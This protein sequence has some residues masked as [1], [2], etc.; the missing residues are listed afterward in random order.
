MKV[1]RV[2][3]ILVGLSL[4][5]ARTQSPS[6]PCFKTGNNLYQDCTSNDAFDVGVCYGYIL[7]AYDAIQADQ[8]ER[9]GST[10]VFCEPSNIV[11]QQVK[12]MV[13]AYLRPP[14][15]R[16]AHRCGG[17][18]VGHVENK[19]SVRN[20][21]IRKRGLEEEI[22]NGH[23]YSDPGYHLVFRC[24]LSACVY[25][26]PQRAPRTYRRAHGVPRLDIGG[27]GWCSDLGNDGHGKR[28]VEWPP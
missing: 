23:N 14:P 22:H 11:V 16:T 20:D 25:R 10:K 3:F 12:D 5:S 26:T 8:L 2:L 9:K 6:V 4:C 28:I 1:I 7:G 24:L 17:L 18:G 27:L 19:V 21:A 13:V 15:G